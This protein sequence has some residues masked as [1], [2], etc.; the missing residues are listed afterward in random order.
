VKKYKSTVAITIWGFNI[1]STCLLDIFK[2]QRHNDGI[3]EGFF[4][5]G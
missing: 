4:P 2:G 5:V 1:S 3:F